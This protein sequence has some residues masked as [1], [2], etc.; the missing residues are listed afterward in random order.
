MIIGKRIRLRGI[1]R[2]DI[3]LFVPWLND[4]EVYAHL[5]PREALSKAEEEQ[6]FEKTLELPVEEHVLMIEIDSQEE[7]VPVGTIALMKID[8]R[9]GSAEIGIFIGEK[10]FWNQGYGREAM[11]L[12]VRH[13]FYDLNLN[14]IFLRVDENNLRA[15]RSYERAGFIEEGRM[16]KARFKDNVYIDTVLMSVLHSEWQEKMD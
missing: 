12:L 9:N 3:A 15:I 4:P 11:Q 8:W 16:R 13:G 6:W 7:W 14:R 2:E 5:T 10:R 1:E